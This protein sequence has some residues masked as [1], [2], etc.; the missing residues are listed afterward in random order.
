MKQNLGVDKII[1]SGT[2]IGHGV[3][4]SAGFL[5]VKYDWW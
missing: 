5:N 3:T 2:T 4:A 1:N